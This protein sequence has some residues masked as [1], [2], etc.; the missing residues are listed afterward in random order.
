MK[1]STVHFF[2]LLLLVAC[3]PNEKKTVTPKALTP[4]QK[5]KKHLR[6]EFSKIAVNY[7]NDMLRAADPVEGKKMINLCLA[8][9]NVIK[10]QPSRGVSEKR[11]FV[12]PQLYGV[13]NREIAS[14]KDFEYSRAMQKLRGKIWD[15]ENLDKFLKRPSHFVPR[16]KMKYPGVLDPQDR[17]DIIS[18]LMVMEKEN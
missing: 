18:Y 12:G 13:F 8:C 6:S 15:V 17:M 7:K 14:L 4:M 3:K 1:P 9:H 16:T 10:G 11:I 5:E 2:L